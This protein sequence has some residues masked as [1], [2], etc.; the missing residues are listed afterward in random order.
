MNAFE[1]AEPGNFYVV[2]VGPG[3]PDLVTLRA[4]SVIRSVDVVLAPR[5]SASESSLALGVVRDLLEEG[6]QAICEHT[7]PMNRD[8]EATRACWE[9]AAQTVAD[10]LAA[11]RSVAHIT[12]G[13]PLIYSTSFYLLEALGHAVADDRIHIIPGISA[14]QAV[15]SRFGDALT[16]QDDRLTLMS[17]ADLTAVEGALDHCETLVL[18]KAGRRLK[19]LRE[20]LER[21]GLLGKA[22][23]VFYAEHEGRECVVSDLCAPLPDAVGYMATVIVDVGRRQWSEGA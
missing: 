17:A 3:A 12:I 9:R 5:S 19:A 15:A 20:L 1:R 2:G 21:K 4:A 18:Y 7:Y 10:H 14:F 8:Q 23:A 22:R 13:D 16:I 11:G 6:R